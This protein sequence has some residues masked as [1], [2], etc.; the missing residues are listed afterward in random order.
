MALL[1]MQAIPLPIAS[2]RANQIRECAVIRLL[3]APFFFPASTVVTSDN[4]VLW[5]KS[6]GTGGAN[7]RRKTLN[8]QGAREKKKTRKIRGA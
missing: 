3:L 1:L 5:R 8:K 6:T 4:I 2:Q 7:I